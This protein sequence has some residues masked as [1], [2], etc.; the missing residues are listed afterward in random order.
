[1]A[2]RVIEHRSRVKTGAM[3]REFVEFFAGFRLTPAQRRIAQTLVEHSSEVPSM[4]ATDVAALANV[5]QPSVTRLAAAVGYSGYK[6]FRSALI[7]MLRRSPSGSE[8]DEPNEYQRAVNSEVENLQALGARLIERKPI[9]SAGARIMRSPVVVTMGHRAAAHLAGYFAHYAAKAHPDVRLVTSAGSEMTDSLLAARSVG[10]SVI[11]AFVLP[12]YPVDTT[13]TLEFAHQLGFELIL[14][15]DSDAAPGNQWAEVLLRADPSSRLI[16]DTHA[17]TL[18]TASMLVQAMCDEAPVLVQQR[19]EDL[20]GSLKGRRVY[21]N[22][23]G[24]T[25]SVRRRT[26]S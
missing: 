5:S 23:T 14:I 2:R 3:S 7:D 8:L 25:P 10:A 18:L 17:A 22:Q 16:F 1:M 20:E 13:Q 4:S 9:R 15:T 19:L 6:E 12:R 24:R 11:V 21:A 26:Q